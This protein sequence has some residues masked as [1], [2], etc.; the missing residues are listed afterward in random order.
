MVTHDEQ[1]ELKRLAKQANNRLARASAG[2]RSALA[3]Y[4]K[5]KYITKSGFFSKSIARS[6]SEYRARKRELEDFL[7]G[8][9]TTKKGWKKLKEENVLK[10]QETLEKMGYNLTE[11]EL[12]IIFED[13]FI[14]SLLRENDKSIRTSIYYRIMN[15]MQVAKDE[16]I[17]IDRDF[18]NK[19]Q[20]DDLINRFT[21]YQL[22]LQF[23]KNKEQK[24]KARRKRKR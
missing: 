22:T 8:K 5:D 19:F 23:L 9:T 24:K 1:K 14:A 21:D 12:T 16:N 17:N 10:A 3:Y 7:S 20:I 15:I 6:E 13:D 11:E 4:M 2:Q 18:I